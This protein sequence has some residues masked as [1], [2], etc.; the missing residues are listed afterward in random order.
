MFKK[1]SLPEIITVSDGQNDYDCLV[2][3]TARQSIAISIKENGDVIIHSPKYSF[4][5]TLKNIAQKNIH[6][7][8]NKKTQ[9]Q[10]R[11]KNVSTSFAENS[12]IKFLGEDYTIKLSS[13]QKDEV[14]LNEN[15]IYIKGKSQLDIKLGLK[16]F[17]RKQ[18]KQ[19]FK[20][21]MEY[22]I[23]FVDGASEK[24][25]LVIKQMSTRWGSMSSLGNM[26][27]NIALI[28]CPIECIDYVIVHELCHQKHM[29]H[30]K[31]FWDSVKKVL[32]EYKTQEKILKLY[33][34]QY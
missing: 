26:N 6:W 13:E 17:Y 5:R 9:Q 29:N 10:I 1:K 7:I 20:D 32:P 14:V 33:S 15:Q 27:L 24:T 23:P 19:I 3:R 8:I 31:D 34:T 28:K 18:A 12:K 22:W 4:K 21:R 25:K 11:Y 16:S 30:S 2:K